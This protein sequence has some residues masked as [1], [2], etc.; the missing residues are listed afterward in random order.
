MECPGC[1]TFKTN[2]CYPLPH[3]PPHFQ[4]LGGFGGAKE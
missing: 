2:I 3:L 4:A 1:V